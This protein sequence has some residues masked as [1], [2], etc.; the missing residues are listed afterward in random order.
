VEEHL[1][2]VGFG[3]QLCFQNA[4]EKQNLPAE[5]PMGTECN[6]YHGCFA[7][8]C[9]FYVSALF[10]LHLSLKF[11]SHL[12]RKVSNWKD[13]LIGKKKKKKNTIRGETWSFIQVLAHLYIRA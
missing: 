11:Y 5:I 10:V 2:A 12:I 3:K 9:P 6:S 7:S 8:I 4:L 1:C 13:S